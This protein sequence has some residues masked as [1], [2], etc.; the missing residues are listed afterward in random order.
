MT[1]KTQILEA[2]AANL[3]EFGYPDAKADNV[4]SIG[5]FAAFAEPQVLNFGHQHKGNAAVEAAVAEI[6][7]ECKATVEGRG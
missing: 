4:T 7:A 6:A 3:R 5:I 2:V 1:I